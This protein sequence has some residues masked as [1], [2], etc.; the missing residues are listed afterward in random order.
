MQIL[1]VDD[2]K[3]K[4]ESIIEIIREVSPG[5]SVDNATYGKECLQFLG[6]TQYDLLILDLNLPFN[7]FEKPSMDGGSK[8]VN[9]IYRKLRRLNLPH[10]IVGLTQYPDIIEGYFNVWK[11]IHYNRSSKDWVGNL[12]KLLTH[13]NHTNKNQNPFLKKKPT[14]L[15]EGETDYNYFHKAFEIFYPQL[16]NDVTLT[17]GKGGGT[18]WVV[19]NSMIWMNSYP[20]DE[21]LKDLIAIAILDNDTAGKKAEIEIRDLFKSEKQREILK[22]LKLKIGFSPR[23]QE[24]FSKGFAI[25]F[26]IEA[27]FGLKYYEYANS[28]GWLENDCSNLEV[29][30]K[31]W[32]CANENLTECLLRNKFEKNSILLTKKIKRNYKDKFCQLVLSDSQSKPK[33]VFKDFKAIIDEIILK[34]NL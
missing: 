21:D 7:E 22:I 13:I 24:Y 18:S 28:N 15:L 14:I 11:V 5:F 16:L 10:Y 4:I 25:H 19:R 29:V 9:E 26:E 6:H 27:L 23:I 31:I 20:K 17:Y 34:L 32:D 3:S 2:D 8:V 1:I 30:P 33:E 12:K